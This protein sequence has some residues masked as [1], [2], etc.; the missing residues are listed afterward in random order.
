[1]C[2]NIFLIY[3]IGLK[4]SLNFFFFPIH[5][6]N[7]SIFAYVRQKRTTFSRQFGTKIQKNVHCMYVS[8]LLSKPKRN[9]T[10]VP[11][12]TCPKRGI[13]VQPSQKKPTMPSHP[14][15]KKVIRFLYT[16]FLI[17]FRMNSHIASVRIYT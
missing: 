5:L 13:N 1:M 7:I 16:F 15:I 14:P 12:K 8:D 11:S 9:W 6:H 3:I 2:K 4:F 17:S 10:F